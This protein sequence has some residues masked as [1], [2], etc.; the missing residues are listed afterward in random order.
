MLPQN[1]IYTKTLSTSLLLYILLI[2]SDIR[3]LPPADQQL[4]NPIFT[5]RKIHSGIN[6]QIDLHEKQTIHQ[7]V[8]GKS[9]H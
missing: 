9:P 4:K 6:E 7:S 1:N 8:P 3:P 5:F 2:L